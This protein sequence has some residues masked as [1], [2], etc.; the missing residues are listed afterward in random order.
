MYRVSTLILY[1]GLAVIYEV[2]I[3]YLLVGE[4]NNQPGAAI[5]LLDP[6]EIARN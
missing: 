1:T 4:F 3:S 5:Y 2:H 6:T